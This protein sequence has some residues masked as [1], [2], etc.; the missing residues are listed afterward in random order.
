MDPFKLGFRNLLGVTVPGALLPLALIYCVLSVVAPLGGPA[1]A[2]RA[3]TTQPVFVLVVLFL[4][5]YVLGSLIRLYAVDLVDRLSPRVFLRRL[6]FWKRTRYPGPYPNLDT[7]E[8]QLDALFK[9]IVTEQDKGPWSEDLIR[10]AWRNDRFPYPVWEFMKFRLYHPSE[11]FRFFVSYERCFG[12]KERRAKEF[13]NYCKLV[14]Y[15]ASHQRGDGLA[16]EVQA[17]EGYSRFFAGSFNALACSCLALIACGVI[18]AA[19]RKALGYHIAVTLVFAAAAAVMGFLIVW[20]GRFRL[21]RLKEVDMVFDAFYLIHRHVE[22]CRQCAESPVP[23]R[24]RDYV[25]RERLLREAFSVNDEGT[26]NYGPVPLARLVALMKRES[27]SNG[28][29]SCMYFA[30]AREDH[31][32][33]L[34]TDRL[35]IGISVLPEDSE[36]AGVSKRHPNQREV[37]FVASGRLRLELQESGS[38][39]ERVLDAGDVVVIHPGQCHRVTPVDTGDAC[40]LFVKTDPAREPT[41]EPCRL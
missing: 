20:G 10:W 9:A 36:K 37:I 5:S 31:P 6:L 35:A 22:E 11:M 41:E 19:Q 16:E 32:Y 7:V 27:V 34:A 3:L 40:Y 26:P 30:G 13:F 4:I 24:S 18:Q 39:V 12:T 29:L 23:D 33:F 17:A 25:D 28:A 21:L 8:D 15:S 38:R 2:N 1:V 14:I